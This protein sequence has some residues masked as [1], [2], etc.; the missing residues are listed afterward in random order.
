A[1]HIE[2]TS[3]GAGT[4]T[5]TVSDVSNHAATIA[6]TVAADGSI[7][8]GTITKYQVTFTA[9][10][11]S[12]TA[13]DVATL[14]L[15]GTTATSDA[16]TVATAAINAGHIE[17]TSVGAGTATI[18]VSDA[19]S[20]AATIAVT[21]AADGSM[22]LGTITKYQVDITT[23]VATISTAQSKFDAATEGTEVGQYAV[24]SKATLQ[25]AIDVATA[26]KNDAN[27]TQ[28]QVD[29]AATT[30]S[31]AV[32]AFEAGKVSAD[33]TAPIAT[34]MNTVTTFVVGTTITGV[35]SNELGSLYL[36]PIAGTVTTKA[37]LDALFTAGTAKRET[38][39]TANTDTNL[40]TTGLTTGEYKVY[41]VDAAG[42]VSS[43]SSATITLVQP[44]TISGGTL[45]NVGGI[46]ATVT[47]T[48]N[49]TGTN[50]HV[51]NEVVIFQLMNGTVPVS[52][53]ALEKDIQSS[54]SLTAYFNVTGTGY[55]VKVFVVDIFNNSF[56]NVGNN[57]ADAATLQLK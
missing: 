28:T 46:K 36:V 47:V 32:A 5:I 41:A 15:V 14:G 20:H 23:L 12:S 25:T 27:A 22:T 57:L 56:T 11:N 55:T 51:G 2:I 34:I 38:V 10:T 30:L 13:N 29:V 17:I 7:T 19:S 35:Q 54:E 37:S 52:I 48:A 42:N 1:G 8:L 53:V 26:L 18:K 9:A 49:G 43:P 40:T 44:F 33:T 24:G 39:S 6:V 21:V 31:D 50:V 16:A 4:A 3:V 45:S